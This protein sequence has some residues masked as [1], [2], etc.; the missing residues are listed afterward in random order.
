MVALDYSMG[1]VLVGTAILGATAGGMGSFAVL[2]KQSLL[3]DCMAHAALPGICVAF[4]MSQ[5]K[6]TATLLVGALVAGALGSGMLALIDRF[7]ILKKDTGLGIVLSVFFGVGLVLLTYIQGRGYAHQSGLHT[8]LFGN[9]ATLLRQDIYSMGVVALIVLLSMVIFWKE[10]V[11]VSFDQEYATVVGFASHWISFAMTCLIAMAIVIGLQSVGVV[12]MSALIIAPAVAARQWT[13]R[14][15]AMVVLAAI[16]GSSASCIGV[17]LSSLGT[18]L[19][20]GPLIVVVTSGIAGLSLLFAPQRGVIWAW[21]RHAKQRTD[22]TG[23]RLLYNLLQ[24]SET[25]INPTVV[26][27][28]APLEAL[29][30]SATLERLQRLAKQGM[31]YSDAPNKWG[32]TQQGLRYIRTR[33]QGHN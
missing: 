11:L 29:G 21:Y 18:Q 20:T 14:M 12:L 27:S 26:H 2:R 1:V 9:A 5:E 32:L 8:Y 16:L 22:M 15:G 3:G 4:M 17:M 10:S 6:N 19:P 28:L 23:D 25:A 31:I 24:F 13:H 33:I 30:E 7:S